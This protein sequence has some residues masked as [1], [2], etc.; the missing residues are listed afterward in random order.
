MITAKLK[1]LNYDLLNANDYETYFIDECITLVRILSECAWKSISKHTKKQPVVVWNES[2]AEDNDHAVFMASTSDGQVAIF[3][4]KDKVYTQSGKFISFYQWLKKH[5]QLL[6]YLMPIGT[7]Y[8]ILAM[9]IHSERPIADKCYEDILEEDE[10]F[11]ES[12]G[13]MRCAHARAAAIK[14]D[15]MLVRYLLDT[16]TLDER[17]L[18]LACEPM[19]ITLFLDATAEERLSAIEKIHSLFAT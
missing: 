15:G 8:N 12:D 9:T 6:P 19:A 17:A 18:A 13:L 16:I 2:S 3:N 7:K 4:F 5:Y 1:E 14:L 11:Y 10:L